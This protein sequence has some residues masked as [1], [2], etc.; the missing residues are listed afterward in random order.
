M[1]WP[2]SLLAVALAL[3]VRLLLIRHLRWSRAAAG[4]LAFLLWP[5]VV[6]VGALLF[7]Q[8]HG[9]LDGGLALIFFLPVAVGVGAAAVA[10]VIVWDLLRV[11]A[12]RAGAEP[13]D[14]GG[15]P[16]G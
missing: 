3:G 1:I 12:R 7:G 16:D 2:A 5:A 8:G 9:G 15:P 13:E 4:V 11:L 10:C 6:V 14:A